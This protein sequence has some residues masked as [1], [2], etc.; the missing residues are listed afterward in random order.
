MDG[1]EE[2][3][4]PGAGAGREKQLAVLKKPDAMGPTDNRR[5]GALIRDVIIS[6]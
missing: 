3:C 2:L 4:S 6:F 1:G 5:H